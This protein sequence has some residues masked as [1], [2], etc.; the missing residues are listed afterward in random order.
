M[1]TGSD[2]L[3]ARNFATSRFYLSTRMR[4]MRERLALIDVLI[5]VASFLPS[6][7]LPLLSFSFFSFFLYHSACRRTTRKNAL[8]G[9]T[10]CTKLKKRD[11]RERVKRRRSNQSREKYTLH[12]FLHFYTTGRQRR[13]LKVRINTATASI[14]RCTRL[15]N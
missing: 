6:F 15:T 7:F 14:F 13:S 8:F 2:K 10:T 1:K 5:D 4:T 11:T 12:F 3:Y 9:M